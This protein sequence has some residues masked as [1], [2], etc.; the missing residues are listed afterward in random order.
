MLSSGAGPAVVQLQLLVTSKVILTVLF[1]INRPAN[2]HMT[3][4]IRCL[5]CLQLLLGRYN[6]Y[7][8]NCGLLP[9]MSVKISHHNFS[10]ATEV[11]AGCC[12]SFALCS[13]QQATQ[14]Y[15]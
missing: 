4:Y 6:L 9:A 12:S 13:G 8:P 11:V 14:R 3:N 7:L 10:S 2:G 15:D 1:S 5:P